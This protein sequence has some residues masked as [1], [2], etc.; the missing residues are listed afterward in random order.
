MIDRYHERPA[1]FDPYGPYAQAWTRTTG[2]RPLGAALR[3]G[4][5][6]AVLGVPAESLRRDRVALDAIL[7]GVPLG[8]LIG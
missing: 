7:A 1:A 6:P 3:P 2:G 5:A 8:D 4:C